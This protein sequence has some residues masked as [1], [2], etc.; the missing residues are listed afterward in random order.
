M[1]V[2]F[3]VCLIPCYLNILQTFDMSKIRLLYHGAPEVKQDAVLLNKLM[4]QVD[5]GTSTPAL[6]CYK[7]ANEMIQAKYALN[8]IAKLEKFNKGK[9]LIKRAFD[10]DTSNLEIRFIRFSI[11]KNLPAFLGYHDELETDK[12]FLLKNNKNNKDPQV[13][14]MIFNYLSALGLVENEETKQLKN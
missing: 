1:K 11:Q 6:L 5:S 2:L 14:E 12:L 3:W 4:L 13:K 9:K 7:G 8:P 10:R